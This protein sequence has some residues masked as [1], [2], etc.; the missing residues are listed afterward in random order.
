MPQS[1]KEFLKT[2]IFEIYKAKQ[3]TEVSLLEI[4]NMEKSDLK[5]IVLIEIGGFKDNEKYFQIKL[6]EL[7]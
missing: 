3:T 4:L 7:F 1:E 6:N 5:K 2:P